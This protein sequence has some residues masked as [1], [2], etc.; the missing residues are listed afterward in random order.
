MWP[1]RRQPSAVDHSHVY[2]IDGGQVRAIQTDDDILSML[3]VG[4]GADGLPLG[5]RTR[6]LSYSASAACLRII[7]TLCAAAPAHIYSIDTDGGRQR[8]RDHVAEKLLNG[9]ASPWE[10]SVDFV[11]E[12]TL[13]AMF[14][15]D[16]LSRIRLIWHE[17]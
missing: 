3:G 13:E 1:F 5:E 7:S 2:M 15:G 6:A 16:A 10:S 9:F 17:L 4:T 11:R 14:E 8:E 12:M